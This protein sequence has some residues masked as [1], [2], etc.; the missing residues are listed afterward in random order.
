M[1]FLG[2]STSIRV[3]LKK[4][5]ARRRCEGIVTSESQ[6]PVAHLALEAVHLDF[7]NQSAYSILNTLRHI[8]DTTSV[9]ESMLSISRID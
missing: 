1:P 7:S 3:R 5:G 4:Q 9:D 2:R 6:L 8:I